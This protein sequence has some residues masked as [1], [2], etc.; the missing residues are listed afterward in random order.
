MSRD[1]WVKRLDEERCGRDNAEVTGSSRLS[2]LDTNYFR[3]NLERHV[4]TLMAFTQKQK[5]NT[6]AVDPQTTVDRDFRHNLP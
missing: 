1:H 6:G 4:T 2:S 5:I 3:F